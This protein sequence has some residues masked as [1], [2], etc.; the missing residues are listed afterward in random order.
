M[1]KYDEV[2]NLDEQHPIDNSGST[3]ISSISYKLVA[4]VVHIGEKFSSGH[5]VCYTKRNGMWYYANDAQIK[6]CTLFKAINQQANL[7]FHERD[8]NDDPVVKISQGSESLPQHNSSH[9]KQDLFHSQDT[10]EV[11]H[12]T[13]PFTSRSLG[14]M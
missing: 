5:Y 9:K 7:L 12:A 10:I 8:T 3:K 2:L 14:V 6:E 13:L 11:Q 1:V 4:I